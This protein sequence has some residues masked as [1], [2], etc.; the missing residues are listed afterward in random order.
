MPQKKE[1]KYKNEEKKLRFR[2]KKKNCW[3]E[4]GVKVLNR[5]S[6]PKAFFKEGKLILAT[7]FISYFLM[8]FG[9]WI[10]MVD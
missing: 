5:Y 7:S 2:Q 10:W 8:L 6:D 4:F 3:S 9:F 1:K